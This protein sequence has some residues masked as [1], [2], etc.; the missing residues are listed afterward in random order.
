MTDAVSPTPPSRTGAGV[1]ARLPTGAKLL[2]FLSAA[3]LPLALIASLAAYQTTRNADLDNRTRLRVAAAEASRTLAIELLG[4]A[5]AART[6][7]GAIERD[8]GDAASCARL[9]GVFAQAL[10]ARVQ[11]AVYDAAGRLRCGAAVRPT[12]PLRENDV[13]MVIVPHQG[14]ALAVDGAAG[15]GR[16]DLFFPIGMLEEVSR[17]TGF[18]ADYALTLRDERDALELRVPRGGRFARRD[19]LNTTVGIGDLQLQMSAPSAPITSPVLV[20]MLFPFLMWALAAGLAWFVVDRLLIRPLRGLQRD[21]DAYQPGSVFDPVA[22][23]AFPASEINDLGDSFRKL[24]RTLVAHEAGLADGLVRQTK[25]T[26]EVHHRVKNNLQVIASLI[27]FHARGA[28]GAPVQQA[29][30]TIQRRVDALAVVH[31]NHYAELEVNRGL[32][33]R[34]VLSELSANI[35]ATAPERSAQLGITLEIEPYFVSQDVAVAVAFLVTELVELAMSVQ[36]TAQLRVS[37]AGAAEP[38]RATL[39]LSSPALIEG[40][41]LRELLAQRYGRVL[42]GL[43]R[44]LRSRLHHDPL[45]GV[46]EITIAV[47]GRE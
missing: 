8:P 34:S 23:G 30:A 42:E 22:L 36:P 38:E 27:N 17:P 26:R 20:A 39:R 29:Y 21:I 4:D 6:A 18:E 5:N 16:A 37:L 1:V 45:L 32:G 31:R 11:F 28:T 10:S 12:A 44:Q 9:R 19:R 25:L 24:T 35:R 41:T 40:D 33:L 15:R 7:L 3:L 46:Y 47:L 13:T 43:A 14:I 2:L